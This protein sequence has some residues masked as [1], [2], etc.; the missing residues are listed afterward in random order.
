MISGDWQHVAALTL[1]TL[2]ALYLLNRARLLFVRRSAAGCSTGCAS[3]PTT[4]GSA[5]PTPLP[6]AVVPMEQLVASAGH[7]RQ[8]ASS[9]DPSR[10][11]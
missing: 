11:P 3:C 5:T 4:A 9:G 8:R 6:P 2:A 10:L 7:C 1:V